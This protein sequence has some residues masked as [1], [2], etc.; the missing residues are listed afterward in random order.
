MPPDFMAYDG[1]TIVRCQSRQQGHSNRTKS[2]EINSGHHSQLI[3]ENYAQERQWQVSCVLNNCARK[4]D[5]YT[6]KRKMRRG[7][8]RKRLQEGKKRG[9]QALL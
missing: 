5:T 6:E 3:F 8:K 1:A 7:R 4:S 2:T 9:K